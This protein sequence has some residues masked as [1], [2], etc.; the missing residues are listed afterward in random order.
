MSVIDIL[1]GVVTPGAQ[2]CNIELD[3]SVKQGSRVLQVRVRISESR[4]HNSFWHEVSIRQLGDTWNQV[5]QSVL[6]VDNGNCQ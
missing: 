4:L 3:V 6:C 5:E 2:K 1:V